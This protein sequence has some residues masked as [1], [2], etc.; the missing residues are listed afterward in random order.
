M[1]AFISA[2]VSPSLCQ[3]VGAQSDAIHQ[4]LV[5][6]RRGQAL[7]QG[8]QAVHLANGEE[9]MKN[10]PVVA[11]VG[12]GAFS[13]PCNCILV[14]TTSRGLVNTQAPQAARPLIKNSMVG[15]APASG[16]GRDIK[17]NTW[18]FAVQTATGRNLKS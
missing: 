14:F 15:V 13:S 5:Q 16:N 10:V 3:P 6:E 1:D 9:G 4:K 2:Q 11:L 12:S 17:A 8:S 18:L 7:L